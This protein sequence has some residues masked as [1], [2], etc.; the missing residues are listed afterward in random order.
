MVKYESLFFVFIVVEQFDYQIYLK[1]S[2]S[3]SKINVELAGIKPLPTS[4]LPIQEKRNKENIQISMC[5]FFY[6]KHSQVDM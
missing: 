4:W 6:R 1:L 2:N 3:T 5:V